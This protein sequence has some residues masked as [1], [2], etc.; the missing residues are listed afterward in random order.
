[1][2]L[3]VLFRR[4]GPYHHARLRAAGK[5]GELVGL[6]FCS[7]DRTYSWNQQ[8]SAEGFRQVTLFHDSDAEEQPPSAV[9]RRIKTAL[10]EIDPHA[11]AIPGW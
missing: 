3:A 1:M 8:K 11:V 7:A 10:D 5:Y 6:E 9:M 2:K 4:F